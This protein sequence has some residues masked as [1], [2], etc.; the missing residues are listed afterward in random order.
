ME[1]EGTGKRIGLL[2]F[3]GTANPQNYAAVEVLSSSG[4]LREAAANLFRALRRLD[5]LSLDKIVARPVREEG[6]GRAIM[7]R[8]RR[9][10]A[11]D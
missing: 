11:R 2:Q 4:N 8:L 1:A 5:A 7:D 3:D 9:C 6:L 10:S